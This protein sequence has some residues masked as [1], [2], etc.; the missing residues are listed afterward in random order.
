MANGKAVIFDLDGTLLDTLCDLADMLNLTL[1][2]HGMRERTLD[3]VRRFIG[4][5]AKKLVQRAVE[6]GRENP[7]FD[8]VFESFMTK[9][10]QNQ[11]GKTAPYPC[12]VELLE[13]L[14]YKGILCGV[15]TNKPDVAA[16][17]VC[18][19]HFGSRLAAVEGDREGKPRKP[20]PDGVL[21]M[22]KR[23]GADRAVYVGDSEVDVLTARAANLPCVAVTW[24]FRSKEIL[25]AA[26]GEMFADNTHELYRKIFEILELDGS[27]DDFEFGEK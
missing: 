13:A 1:R 14:A 27:P 19:K 23:L 25:E 4:D 12:I 6:G 11:G 3:E 20:Q 7:D 2:E 26:G 18:E 16:K 15:V 17:L 24:G 5:G 9:Y 8:A 10:A 22:M 21:E